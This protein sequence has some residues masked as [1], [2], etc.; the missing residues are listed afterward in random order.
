MIFASVERWFL[1]TASIEKQA[2]FAEIMEVFGNKSEI[3]QFY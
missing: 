3:S 2:F 1:Y